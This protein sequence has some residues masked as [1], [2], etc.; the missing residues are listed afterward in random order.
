MT[1][2]TSSASLARAFFY[3]DS[4]LT[5]AALADYGFDRNVYLLCNSVAP[6]NTDVQNLWQRYGEI[7][8]QFATPEEAAQHLYMALKSDTLVELLGSDFEWVRTGMD[9]MRQCS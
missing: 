6:N 2:S 4:R 1:G 7:V 3:V 5:R 9:L 8:R